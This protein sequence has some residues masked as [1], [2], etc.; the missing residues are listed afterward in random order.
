MGQKRYTINLVGLLFQ[1][2]EIGF[3]TPQYDQTSEEPNVSWEALNILVNTRL[4]KTGWGGERKKKGNKPLAFTF[5]WTFY[6]LADKPLEQ[7]GE[8]PQECALAAPAAPGLGQ[9]R[10]QGTRTA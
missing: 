3:Q 10:A 8:E 5:L 1:K 9:L 6:I 7:P 2:E 4:K